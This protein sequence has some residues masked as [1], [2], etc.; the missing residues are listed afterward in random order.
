MWE[1]TYRI[2]SLDDLA[3]GKDMRESL[4]I[5]LETDVNEMGHVCFYGEAG[6]GK[7]SVARLISGKDGWGDKTE[8][9]LSRHELQSAAEQRRLLQ[10]ISVVKGGGLRSFFGGGDSR[11]DLNVLDEFHLLHKSQQQQLNATLQDE[12]QA[13]CFIVITNDIRKFASNTMDRFRLYNFSVIDSER[14]Q[15]IK[16]QVRVAKRIL[17]FFDEDEKLFTDDELTAI[18][19]KSTR[20]H[21]Q[22][23]AN[24]ESATRRKKRT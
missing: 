9:D 15:V 22:F 16:E 6:R 21:R 3:F 23:V 12:A 24:L 11:R 2:S 7:T 14:K 13:A 18:A 19:E 10:S 4:D 5:L 20:S 1:L 8:Y 17:T